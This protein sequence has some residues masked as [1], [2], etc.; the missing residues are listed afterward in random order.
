[1]IIVGVAIIEIQKKDH[2]RATFP[3]LASVRFCFSATKSFPVNWKGNRL[4]TD[5]NFKS[6]LWSCPSEKTVPK[7]TPALLSR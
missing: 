5:L 1:M 3:I 2:K 6:V 7:I 4:A